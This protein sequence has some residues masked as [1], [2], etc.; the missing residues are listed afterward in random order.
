MLGEH[1][2]EIRAIKSRLDD[3]EPKLDRLVS[4]ADR[5]EGAWKSGAWALGIAG[6]FIGAVVSFVADLL[7]SKMA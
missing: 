4:F 6:A 5:V 7:R 1:A 2:A 3:M